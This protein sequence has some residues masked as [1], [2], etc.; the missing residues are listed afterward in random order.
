MKRTQSEC[1]LLSSWIIRKRLKNGLFSNRVT[2]KLSSDGNKEPSIIM[3]VEDSMAYTLTP[4]QM[5][6]LDVSAK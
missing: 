3:N 4:E 6:N 1:N 5:L 2:N